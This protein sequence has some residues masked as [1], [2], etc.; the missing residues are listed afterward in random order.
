MELASVLLLM[1]GM[2]WYILF[3]VLGGVA[4]IPSDLIQTAKSFGLKSLLLS[5]KLVI[6]AAAPSLVTG[7]LTGWGGG[8]NALVVAEY[9]MYKNEVM[10]VNGIG[11]LLNQSVFES[12]DGREIALCLVAMVA[13]ILILNFTFWRPLYEWATNRFQLEG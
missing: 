11:S 2:Q 3:N 7:S 13:W 1:T 4:T 6:P 9:V 10:K 8:W 12:G 5:R